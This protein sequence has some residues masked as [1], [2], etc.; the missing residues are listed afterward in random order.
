MIETDDPN[1][2]IR[3][4]RRYAFWSLVVLTIGV[5]AFTWRF[6]AVA[7]VILAGALV[8]VNFQLMTRIVDNM[9]DQP[10]STPTLGKLVFLATRLVLLALLL[11]GI[12]LVPGVSPIP[13]ALGLSVLVIAVLIEAFRQ[14][15][16][17]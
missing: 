17:G 4:L 11:C 15:F 14:V 6:G 16:S 5:A 9:L 8:L 12:F 10:H 1:E 7:G 3:R 13:V 2:L